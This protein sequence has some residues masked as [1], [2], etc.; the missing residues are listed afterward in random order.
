MIRS[1][2]Q[3]TISCEL[4]HGF[5]CMAAALSQVLDK[6]KGSHHPCTLLLVLPTGVHMCSSM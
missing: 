4:L 2:W 1:E 5:G 6:T 3:E